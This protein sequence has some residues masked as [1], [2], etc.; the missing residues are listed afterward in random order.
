MSTQVENWAQ[1]RDNGALRESFRKSSSGTDSGCT[2]GS[3]T[4]ISDAT[5]LEE[6]EFQMLQEIQTINARNEGVPAGVET[7]W[8]STEVYATNINIDN[9]QSPP[10]VQDKKKSAVTFLDF[11]CLQA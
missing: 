11:L 9:V 10:Q 6:E 5:C 1:D 2:D 4:Q 8:I 3:D 7:K